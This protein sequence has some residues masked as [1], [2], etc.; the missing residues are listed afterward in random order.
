MRDLEVLDTLAGYID[1]NIKAC[2]DIIHDRNWTEHDNKVD[3][4]IWIILDGELRVEI[5]KQVFHVRKND[6]FFLSPDVTYQASS[7]TDRCHFIYIHFDFNIG[8]N[9]KVLE[10]YNLEGPVDGTSVKDETEAVI[11][12]YFSY[13]N[14][15]LL[16][17]LTFKGYL[18]VL[19]SKI[20]LLKYRDAGPE[21]RHRRI[22]SKP[23]TKLQPV[24]MHISENLHEQLSISELAGLMGVSEKYFIAYFRNVI[25]TTPNKFIISQKMSKALGYLYEGKY[26][27]KEI[28]M[29][30]G[31]SDQYTFSKAFKKHYGVAPSVIKKF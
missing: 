10:G 8:N 19:V 13:K 17:L 23:L 4:D 12:S 30:V 5:E 2:G 21:V 3:Y 24:L 29:L 16:S 27:V 14:R 20:M 1:I 18:T 26:S 9:T 31:Y 11:K 28:S 6:V 25:G 22:V 7:V 15:N